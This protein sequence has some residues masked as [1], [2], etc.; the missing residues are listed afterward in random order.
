MDKVHT[1][2]VSKR[3]VISRNEKFHPI[4]DDPSNVSELSRFLGTLKRCVPLT[5]VSWENVPKYL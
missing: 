4:F 2:P 5:Y 1:R 3:I